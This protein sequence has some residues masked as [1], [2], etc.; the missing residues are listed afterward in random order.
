[1]WLQGLKAEALWV[2]SCER[3][4]YGTA[5]LQEPSQKSR[6]GGCTAAWSWGSSKGLHCLLLKNEDACLPLPGQSQASNQNSGYCLSHAS[7]ALRG[8]GNSNSQCGRPDYSC[9]ISG[10]CKVCPPPWTLFP[11]AAVSMGLGQ[12]VIGTH[13][14]PQQRKNTYN[15]RDPAGH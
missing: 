3:R 5:L 12:A 9:R 7:Q 10:T 13:W 1:M 15:P 14:Q 6:T 8:R 4:C 11:A 2:L